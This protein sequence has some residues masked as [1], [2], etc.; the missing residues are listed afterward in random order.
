MGYL[1]RVLAASAHPIVFVAASRPIGP[2]T[3][4]GALVQTLTREGRLIRIPLDRLS[5]S[6]TAHLAQQI[7]PAF[8]FPLADWLLQQSEG[9]PYILSESINYARESGLL[10]ADE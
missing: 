2:R 9:N 4:I 1:A 3:P 8:A 10:Y 7:S 5:S 6:D